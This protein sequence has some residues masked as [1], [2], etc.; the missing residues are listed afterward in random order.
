MVAVTIETRPTFSTGAS[1]VLFS[2]TGL[3][4]SVLHPQCDASPDDQRV[5]T[6][7]QP[8]GDAAGALILVLNVFEELTR[9]AP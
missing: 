5:V 7:R 3:L 8:I 4:S 1:A 2:E 9:Q 6:V